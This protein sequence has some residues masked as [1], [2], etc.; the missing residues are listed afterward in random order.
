MKKS[1]FLFFSLVTIFFTTSCTNRK[2]KIL[3]ERIQYDV[4]II[5]P[6][7]D[8]EWWVQNLE[9]N[10]REQLVKTIMEQSKSGKHKVYDVISF[11]E[12][13]PK[14]I[15]ERSQQRKLMTLQRDYAPYEE[16]DTLVINNIELS[17]I[18]KV[19]FL[20]EWYLNEESGLIT[21]KVLAICPMLE[22]YTESG[23]FRGH[24]PLYWISFEKKFPLA[25]D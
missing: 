13:T 6:E 10:K 24:L 7:K 3:T 14:E 22:S 12:L 8:L 20:E 18:S 4:T 5:S 25:K 2:G 11:K 23:E 1:A 15:E 9:N 17:D 19:R 16:Y 21:K